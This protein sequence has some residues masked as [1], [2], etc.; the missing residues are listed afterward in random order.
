MRRLSKFAKDMWERVLSTYVQ[1]FLGASTVSVLGSSFFD[2]L[3]RFD[4]NEKLLGS[5][6]TAGVAAILAVVKAQLAKRV[7]NT[8]S[9]ASLASDE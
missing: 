2:E 9:P 7:A 5:A 6:A 1:A 8:V 3:A 4:L